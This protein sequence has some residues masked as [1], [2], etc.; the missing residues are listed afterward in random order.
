MWTWAVGQMPLKFRDT[1]GQAFSP[2]IRRYV[3]L[4]IHQDNYLGKKG[5]VDN[6][7]VRV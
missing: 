5:L 2:E 6:S 1:F 3:A 4:E 7:G